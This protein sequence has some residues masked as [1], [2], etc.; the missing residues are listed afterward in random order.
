MGHAMDM[1]LTGRGVPADEA[2]HMGLVNRVVAK[3]AAREEAITL[4]HQLSK[5]PQVCMNSDRLS[6]YEQLGM[7]LDEA[8]LN[9]FHHGKD[10]LKRE[11]LSGATRF[12]EGKGRG[13]DCGDNLNKVILFASISLRMQRFGELWSLIETNNS[14]ED[15]SMIKFGSILTPS[16]MITATF[17]PVWADSSDD[18]VSTEDIQQPFG[19]DSG[20]YTE[21]HARVFP[22]VKYDRKGEDSKLKVLHVPL[23]TMFEAKKNED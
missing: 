2:L 16:A 21:S 11:S 18:Y 19:E 10:A 7:L 8:I 4:A 6:A 12:T 5:F 17:S 23:V 15:I 9:E 20:E 1:I 22:L 3:G 14:E 13:G